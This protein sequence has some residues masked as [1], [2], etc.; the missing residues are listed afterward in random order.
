MR[1]REILA[2]G[3]HDRLLTGRAAVCLRNRAGEYQESYRCLHTNGKVMYCPQRLFERGRQLRPGE[4][5]EIANLLLFLDVNLHLVFYKSKSAR[6]P[7]FFNV[8]VKGGRPGFVTRSDDFGALTG[9]KL[10]LAVIR[11]DE[12]ELSA[13]ERRLLRLDRQLAIGAGKYVSAAVCF[14][15]DHESFQPDPIVRIF[16]T[17]TDDQGNLQ[18]IKLKDVPI[19]DWYRQKAE[20]DDAELDFIVQDDDPDALARPSTKKKPRRPRAAD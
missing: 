15:L 16:G 10:F 6:E 14:F 13:E 7:P 9:D 1:E 17:Y 19:W 3:L 18:R 2:Q 5:L 20:G 4:G 12:A 11:V 8:S